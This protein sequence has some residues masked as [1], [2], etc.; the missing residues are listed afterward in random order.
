MKPMAKRLV[1]AALSSNG[2]YKVSEQGI[3]EKWSCP[4]TC[5]KHSTSVPRHREIS[6]G[7]VRKIERHMACLPEGW[8]R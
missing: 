4:A 5:G 8:L 1:V 3:H 2:C 7:V 6:P